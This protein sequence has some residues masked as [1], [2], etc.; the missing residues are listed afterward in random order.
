MLLT[1]L[2][3]S[4]RALGMCFSNICRNNLYEPLILFLYA[5]STRTSLR[6]L[7]LPKDDD[8]VLRWNKETKSAVR[9]L[10]LMYIHRALLPLST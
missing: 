4:V 1:V 9:V 10:L 5:S 6:T 7:V 2:V 8:A 3:S